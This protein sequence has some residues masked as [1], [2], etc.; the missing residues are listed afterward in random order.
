MHWLVKTDKYGNRYAKARRLGIQYLIW[1]HKIWGSYSASSGW[2]KYTG[3]NPHTDHVHISFTWAGARKKTSFW[4]GKVGN[5]GAAPTPTLPAAD[6]TPRRP[7][8]RRRRH[9]PAAPGAR[10]RGRRCRR[11]RSS[12]TRP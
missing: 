3:A 11:A 9:H 8:P 10:A 4:T 5:V 7:R 1:N 6:P 12:P 2:R